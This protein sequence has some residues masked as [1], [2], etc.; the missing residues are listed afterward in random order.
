MKRLFVFTL[1]SFAIFC[2][3]YCQFDSIFVSEF[4]DLGDCEIISSTLNESGDFVLQEFKVEIEKTGMYYL[5]AWVNGS[6]DPNGEKLEYSVLVNDEKEEYKIR[7]GESHPHAIDFGD[8][9]LSLSS[10]FNKITFQTKKPN[11]PNIEFIKL[12]LDEQNHRISSE[13]YDKYIDIITKQKLPYNYNEIKEAAMDE[14]L[15]N[16]SFKS[17]PP[18]PG[19]NYD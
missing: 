9:L 6:L 19:C 13:I 5:A 4:L 12:S 16:E 8:K 1:I 11:C 3:S 7:A 15:S 10:G 14:E 2:T 17:D 18:D